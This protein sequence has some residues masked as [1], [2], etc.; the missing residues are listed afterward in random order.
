MIDKKKLM[1]ENKQIIQDIPNFDPEIFRDITGIQI[2][3]EE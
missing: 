3:G 2:G 1:E